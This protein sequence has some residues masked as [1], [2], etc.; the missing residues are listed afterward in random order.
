MRDT[1]DSAYIDQPTAVLRPP[2]ES[3][4]NSQLE[5]RNS[6]VGRKP[7]LDAGFSRGAVRRPENRRI[8]GS[9]IQW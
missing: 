5:H 7:V 1:E 4:T 6:Q 8:S 3:T 2:R 9:S